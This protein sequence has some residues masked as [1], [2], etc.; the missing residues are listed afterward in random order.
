MPEAGIKNKILKAVEELPAA[1][2]IENVMERLLSLLYKIEKGV[3]EA[4]E[5]RLVS[6]P[7]A[8]KRSL[9]S[10]S[11]TRHGWNLH[12]AKGSLFRNRTIAP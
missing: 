4:D 7:D 9:K 8:N 5:G 3:K 2:G 11:R 6:H 1:V 10:C 12:G